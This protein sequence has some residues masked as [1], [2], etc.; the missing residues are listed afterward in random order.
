M[1][2][3]QGHDT[4]SSAISFV[5]YLLSRH[6]AVQ[7]K[8]YEEQQRIMGDHMKR[9]ATFQ[10]IA[11]MKYLDMVIKETLRLYPSV[12]MVGRHTEMEYNMS[13]VFF[14]HEFQKRIKQFLLFRWQTH[15]RGHIPK[16]LH[17]VVGLQRA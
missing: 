15:T 17:H 2:F 5:V 10:E 12:P 3:F 7:A 14:R 16:H 13:R 6:L 11:D 9:D 4:T 8:V 1:R